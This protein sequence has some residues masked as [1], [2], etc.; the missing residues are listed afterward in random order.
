[1]M[2]VLLGLMPF[3]IVEASLRLLGLPRHVPAVDPFVD[4][5]NLR[6]LFEPDPEQPSMLRISPSR[7]HL[8]RPARFERAK[9][10]GT[11][12]VFALGGS[13]TQ[14]EPYST[15]TAFPT[16]MGLCLET[17]A[18]RDVEV[19]NCGGLSYA[20]YR[21]LAI[22][23]EVLEYSPDLIVI[24][25][26]QNE[27]LE[28]RSYQGYELGSIRARSLSW[29]SELRTVQLLRSLVGK[30]GFR[31]QPVVNSPTTLA[32]EVDALLDYEGGLEDYQRGDPWYEPVRDHFLFNVGEMV[33]LC[34]RR[35]VPLVLVKPVSNLLDCPPFKFQEKPG[36]SPA[37]REGFRAHWQRARSS[38]DP[39]EAERA[40]RVALE[41]DPLHAGANYLLGKLLWAQSDYG[42]AYTHLLLAKD[43][44]VC[45]LRAPTSIAD[46]VAEIAQQR[47]VP[48]VDAEELFSRYSEH[49]VVGSAWLVDHIHPT[50]EG[51]QLLGREVAEV[52]L[53]AELLPT[54]NSLW[55]E[56]MEAIFAE[57]LGELGEEYFHR[58]HQRLEGLML[59]TQGR[60]KKV[61]S[62]QAKASQGN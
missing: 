62:G 6:P 36:L 31:E 61:R 39:Q 54:R 2:A 38:Q 50:I 32:S 33:E 9:P 37:D 19:I 34:R 26:G 51:H 47:A 11:Y 29:L 3:V 41:I 4:L 42:Q 48:C 60:A 49:G 44:D 1:M 14:G 28:H 20:S 57:H 53:E 5:H 35:S 46:A 52:C 13:T 43:H 15:Q 12:R 10:S 30:S 21:V 27:Y 59:W 40:V 58:G 18:E 7:L 24:Y 56:E 8:F 55:Q 23:R 17:A 16:W 22:L 25:T 45:P